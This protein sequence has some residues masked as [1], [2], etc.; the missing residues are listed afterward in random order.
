MR[1]LEH[2]I[3]AAVRW[4]ARA[5]DVTRRPHL[6]DRFMELLG[7]AIRAECER[8]QKATERWKVELD[9][10][11]SVAAETSMRAFARERFESLGT[12]PTGNMQL[13]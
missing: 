12:G 9:Q 6:P 10:A 4:R 13:Q 1:V 2:L 5:Y 3:V 8:R 7:D 11:D